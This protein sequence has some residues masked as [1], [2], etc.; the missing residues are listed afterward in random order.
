MRNSCVILA[1]V[2]AVLALSPLGCRRTVRREAGV[3]SE[4][5]GSPQTTDVLVDGRSGAG[6]QAAREAVAAL[7]A[8]VD[9]GKLLQD[10]DWEIAEGEPR[11]SPAVIKSGPGLRVGGGHYLL[12]EIRFTAEAVRKT[13]FAG[14]EASLARLE[15]PG[16]L[17]HVVAL[18]VLDGALGTHR[19]LDAIAPISLDGQEDIPKEQLQEL[20]QYYSGRFQKVVAWE[21]KQNGG[22]DQESA[23]PEAGQPNPDGKPPEAPPPPL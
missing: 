7:F 2:V 5:S 10:S 3:T 19:F 13:G 11:Y 16:P 18:D 23:A 22:A 9:A 8:M 21:R 1:V 15:E 4:V 17:A 14:I 20:H 12:R 6:C